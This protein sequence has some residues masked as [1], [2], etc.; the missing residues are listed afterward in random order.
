MGIKSTCICTEAGKT[1]EDAAT[2]VS[3]AL[4]VIEAACSLPSGLAG[5]HLSQETTQ[6]HTIHEPLVNPRKL[7]GRFH[8]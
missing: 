4:E 1:M 3:E 6:T 7:S 8:C 5:S 2:E